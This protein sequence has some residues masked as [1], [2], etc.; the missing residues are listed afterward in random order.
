MW[1]VLVDA[2][3]YV[4]LLEKC[5]ASL[6]ILYVRVFLPEIGLSEFCKG[7]LIRFCAFTSAWAFVMTVKALAFVTTWDFVTALQ[8]LGFVT[9]WAFVMASEAI[10]FV[11]AWDF[12]RA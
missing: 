1:N 3:K 4:S 2:S 10:A 11:T 7:L 8:V 12:L 6:E 9:G 5:V